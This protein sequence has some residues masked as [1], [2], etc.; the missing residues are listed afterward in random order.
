M[1]RSEGAEGGGVAQAAFINIAAK[2]QS[3]SL[4]RTLPWQ[5]LPSGLIQSELDE[6][7]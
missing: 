4:V 7:L 6:V 2:G 3:G 1:K 5:R